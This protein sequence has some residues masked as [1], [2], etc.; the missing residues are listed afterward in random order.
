[1]SRSNHTFL[2][3]SSN[4]S[5]I[6]CYSRVAVDTS[7]Q[8]FSLKLKLTFGCRL[9]NGVARKFDWEGPKLEKKYDIILM[10]IFGDVMVIASLK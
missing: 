5:K 9:I 2:L 10:T 4:S 1:M 6:Y 8:I 7:F 3:L